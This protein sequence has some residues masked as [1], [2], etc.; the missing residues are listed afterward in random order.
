MAIL[1]PIY[2]HD[3]E[4]IAIKAGETLIT[5]GR[6]CDDIDSMAHWLFGEGLKPGDRVTLHANQVAN[7]SYWDWIMHLGAI[8][9][10]LA[11]STGGMPP[12]IAASGAIGPYAAAIGKIDG[13]DPRAKPRF[14]LAFAPQT[15]APLAEQ[16]TIKD[17]SRSLDGLEKQS[18]R[19]LSTSG[20]TGQPKVVKWD[21]DLFEARLK[22]VREIGDLTPDTMLLTLLGLITTTGLRYPLAAWQMGATVLLISIGAD[23]TDIAEAAYASTFL[24]T[25]PFRMQ[26]ILAQVAGE[27]PGRE[28]RVIELFGGRVPP[29]TREQALERCC[30]NLKMSYGATEVGRVAAGDAALV[31]RDG[32]AVGMVEPGIT[33]EIVDRE[34]TPRP[35]GEPGIVRL[36]SDFMVSGY[37]GQTAQGPRSSFRDG[38]FYPGDIGVVFEDGLFAITGRTSETLNVSGAK[39]SPIILEERLSKLPEVKDICV[40]AMQLDRGDVLTAA[41]VC[42]DGTDLKALRQKMSK[43]VPQQFPFMMFRVPAIPRNAMGRIPR[44]QVAKRLA[45]RMAEAKAKAE[46]KG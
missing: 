22:Q 29:Y 4:R 27:W 33:V 12:A 26:G 21:A 41:V 35:A 28:T 6:L 38:W 1:E 9:A 10:G 46:A 17:T 23:E 16:L 42:A 39:L 5:Y 44:Q 45:A 7:T 32:G 11:Q 31:D 24:A 40:V 2:S 43:L 25:S 13:M 14:K 8:R 20:T 30:T 34:G 36:K 37:V 18:I 3:R 19:L 15:A